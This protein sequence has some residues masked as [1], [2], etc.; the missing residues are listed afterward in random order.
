[1][2][3]VSHLHAVTALYGSHGSPGGYMFQDDR[4]VLWIHMS[5]SGGKRSPGPTGNAELTVFRVQV[6]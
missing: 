6:K 4:T 1:M 3:S 2:L 5:D